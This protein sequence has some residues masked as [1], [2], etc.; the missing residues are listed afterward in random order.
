MIPRTFENTLDKSK[1]INS[2]STSIL[3]TNATRFFASFVND[4]NE[5]IYLSLGA[6][7]VMN[8]GIRLN[9]DGGSF[10]INETN[11][12]IGPVSAICS[13]GGKRLTVL[14]K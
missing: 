3:S 8:Q 12:Y 14:E 7:A 11:L 1:N 10:E 9:A 5:T 2:T 6:S 4:S 13:S